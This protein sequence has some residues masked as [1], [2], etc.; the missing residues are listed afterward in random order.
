M[1][2]VNTKPTI[3][4]VKAVVCAVLVE[5]MRALHSTATPTIDRAKRKYRDSTVAALVLVNHAKPAI[6]PLIV[7][8]TVLT[9]L[10]M[11]A[12]VPH[13][14]QYADLL[15]PICRMLTR[16]LLSF[17]ATS[18]VRKW[19]KMTLGTTNIHCGPDWEKT[20]KPLMR[21]LGLG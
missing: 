13:A 21:F 2:A 1:M 6:F 3:A 16:N 19:K 18:S 9:P 17:S 8:M 12:Y 11:I 20:S 10:A 15:N 7:R 4:T 14:D 5:L